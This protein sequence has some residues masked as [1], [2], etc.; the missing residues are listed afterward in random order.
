MQF[1]RLTALIFLMSSSSLFASVIKTKVN[2]EGTLDKTVWASPTADKI[3][4]LPGYVTYCQPPTTKAILVYP[5]APTELADKG[6]WTQKMSIGLNLG[7]VNENNAELIAN[8][9]FKVTC[10]VQ[11]NE[12]TALEITIPI[13]VDAYNRY[14]DQDKYAVNIDDD[15]TITLALESP[16]KKGAALVFGRKY[17]FPMPAASDTKARKG[18]FKPYSFPSKKDQE[19]APAKAGEPTPKGFRSFTYPAPKEGD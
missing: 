1:I 6:M 16:V 17:E 18:N 13:R 11:I 3:V 15:R 14:V 9:L 8:S 5:F 19:A 2:R 10:E 7:P 4:I 12:N